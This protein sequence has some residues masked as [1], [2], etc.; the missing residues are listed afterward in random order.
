MSTVPVCVTVSVQRSTLYAEWPRR[1][2]RNEDSLCALV[3]H[4]CMCRLL[5]G[6][7]SRCRWAQWRWGGGAVLGGERRS[8]LA[9][10]RLWQLRRR[11]RCNHGN[12]TEKSLRSGCCLAAS[13]SMVVCVRRITSSVQHLNLEQTTVE[14]RK[15]KKERIVW[16]GVLI[17]LL[18]AWRL[19]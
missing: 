8:C 18:W 2:G 3:L 19:I 17:L 9:N 14:V 1:H 11:R 13:A 12:L 10:C 16:G 4:F 7:A 5:R 15:G 6:L